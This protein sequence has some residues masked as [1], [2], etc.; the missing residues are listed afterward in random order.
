MVKVPSENLVDLVCEAED[1]CLERFD[2]DGEGRMGRDG[3]EEAL[4][5]VKVPRKIVWIEE[6]NVH[7][8]KR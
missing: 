4:E 2:E 8:E 5:E 3:S 7:V 1:A 6:G